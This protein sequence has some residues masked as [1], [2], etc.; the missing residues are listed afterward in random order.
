MAFSFLSEYN[1][2]DVE[3]C[4]TYTQ[5]IKNREKS[6]ADKIAFRFLEDGVNES[7]SLTYGQLGLSAKA[8]G[9]NLQKSGSKGD[10]VLLI[11]QPGLSYVKSLFACL[12]TGFIGVPAYPP[13]RNKGIDRILTIL[14][15][16]GANI[17]LT[18]RQIYSDIQRNFKDNKEFSYLKWIIVDDINIVDHE[19]FY[20]EQLHPRDPSII[21][22]TSGSTGNPKGVVITQQNLLY[23]SEYIRQSFDHDSELVGVNWL[24]IFHDMGLIGTVLQPPYV[25]GTSVLMPPMAF[26]KNPVNWLKG[27]QKYKA[28]TVGGPNFTYEYCISKISNEDI[29]EIDL[30]S[31]KIAFCGAEPIRK[32]TYLKFSSKFESA[33]FAEKQFYSCYGMAET[34]LIV[35]GGY[36]NEKPKY[37]S[38][39]T[40]YLSENKVVIVSEA[41]KNST[42]LVGCGH[43]WL[44]TKTEIVNPKTMQKCSH[45]EVGEIW[46][47]GPTVADGYWNNPEETKRTFGAM[48]TDLNEGPFLRTGDLGFFHEKE[49]FITGRIKDL[50]IIR[51]V[52][53]YP[54]DIEYSIQMAI[55]EVR[56]NGGAAFPITVDDTE[57]LV[58][59]QELERKAMRDTDHNLI[60]EKIREVI[61]DEHEL[62][63]YSIVLIRAGSVPMTSSGKIQHRQTKYEYLHGDL[64][65]VA[66]WTKEKVNSKDV[67]FE[68][69]TVPTEEAIKEWVILWIM[70]NQN[71][72]RED[73]DP[74]K[75]IM[76]YGIDSLAAVTLETEISKQFGF[77]WHVS[78]FILNPTIN[79]L[80]VEGMEI[81]MEEND[82]MSE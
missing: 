77:Q 58:V 43:T 1:D 70:R 33:G 39:D 61:A 28:T 3:N 42:S 17:C 26:L 51:G 5:V 10:S 8:I 79:K 66:S 31:I 68:E 54:H 34:T 49:L 36:R 29:K 82:A 74:D 78:S 50:I 45:D 14:K 62:E 30:T 72:R 23:N 60:I 63:V 65:I 80:V 40:I 4:T 53:Y 15:D 20:E 41:N 44:D 35:T 55:P 18:T 2:P 73:I 11:F 27:I 56:P 24:P 22:Y 9:N 6:I 38:V 46:I 71:F 7:E 21:Q 64:S 37:L 32:S 13:R 12:Y 76:T 47:S 57:K 52:N 69:L 25:G 19:T 16:S 81:Y 75:N 48:I 59:V 67:N